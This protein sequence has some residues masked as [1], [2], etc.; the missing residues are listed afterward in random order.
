MVF[1]EL[2][3]VTTVEVLQVV[4]LTYQ[5]KSVTSVITSAAVRNSILHVGSKIHFPFATG[6]IL[7]ICCF[8]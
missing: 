2:S 3:S 7:F 4:N 5:L 6:V 1:A 8:V